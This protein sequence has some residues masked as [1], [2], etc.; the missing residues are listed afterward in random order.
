MVLYWYFNGQQRGD[1]MK[2][3]LSVLAGLTTASFLCVSPVSADLPSSGLYYL[4]A[5]HSGKCLHQHGGN[6]NEGGAVTQW[7]C[8]NQRNVQVEKLQAGSGYFMLRFRHSG[9]CLT[10]LNEGRTNGTPIVQQT[11]NYEGPIGQTWKQLP[12]QGAYVKI[13]STTGLCLHQHG[14]TFGD[15]DRITG[16]ECVDQGN[17]RW[18]WTPAPAN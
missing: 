15:G 12:G 16:W 5:Q 11:C 3:Y 2:Y 14:A 18:K 6:Q 1:S 4:Q 8:I 17:V 7:K 10:V 13:Q 9:K